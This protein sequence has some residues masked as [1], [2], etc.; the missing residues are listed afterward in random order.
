MARTKAEIRK[1]LDSQVGKSV[2]AKSGI[3]QGQCV[4]LIK[5]LL[6][7]LGAPNPY[8]A[9][10]NAKD[11][12]DTLVRQ[13]IARDK[14]GWL[15]VVVNRSMGVIG[16]VRYGHVWIDLRGETNYEQ[17]GARALV[18]TKGTRPY[19]Q[20]QQV[21]TLD[22]YVKADPKPAKKPASTRTYTV[23]RGDT[24]SGIAAKY[25]MTL[26][27]LAKLNPQVK[28][29]LAYFRPQCQHGN[30]PLAVVQHLQGG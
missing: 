28:N 13:G 21:V 26:A 14:D 11:V 12:G 8:A 24:M 23:K 10:G 7:Y 15:R 29:L 1:F 30:S 3:Y 16:G 9:R 25:K 20:R 18:T 5:A 2:N 19:S 22:K 17:N 27:A 6:E 4:S